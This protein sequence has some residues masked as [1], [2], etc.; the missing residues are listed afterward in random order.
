MDHLYNDFTPFYTNDQAQN[1]HQVAYIH[2][3]FYLL[4][5]VRMKG[6]QRVLNNLS[7]PKAEYLEIHNLFEGL[8]NSSLKINIPL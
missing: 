7:S 8:N 5:Q 4:M 1:D 2:K 3:Y 6:S